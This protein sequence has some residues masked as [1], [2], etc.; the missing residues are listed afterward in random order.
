ME[1]KNTYLEEGRKTARMEVTAGQ[2]AWESPS[3][4]ALVKYWGKLPGQIPMNASVS[5]V[6][7][8]SVVRI[9]LA[10]QP[11]GAEGAGLKEFLLNGEPH[12]GFRQRIASYLESLSPYFPFLQG[13]ALSVKSEST[14]PHSAGIA[15]SAA[16]FSALA[17]CLCHMEQLLLGRAV[18]ATPASGDLGK[19]MITDSRFLQKASFFARLGSGSACRS[20]ESGFVVWGETPA[21][22]GSGNEAGV[23]VQDDQVDQR[24]FTLRDAILVI[25]DAEKKVSSSAGHAL[26]NAHPYREPRIGQATA[27]MEKILAAMR[28]GDEA[29]FFSV[30]ENEALSLHSLMMSSDPGYVLMKPSTL[31]VLEKIWAFRER[32]GLALGFTMDAGPNIHLI[33][34]E[35]DADRI[36]S[37]IAEELMPYLAGGTWIDDGIGQG[38]VPVRPF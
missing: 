26:M 17:L 30:L 35:R 9:S 1:L 29:L 22:P 23:R 14:F 31:L 5:F 37:F 18:G 27:N 34:F 8:A 11:A 15:S 4:I 28:S 7:K 2:I 38:P 33:Y 3:N 36:R 25:D 20:L 16:A 12:A 32:S 13:M 10:W 6:L 19:S 21:V 24:F